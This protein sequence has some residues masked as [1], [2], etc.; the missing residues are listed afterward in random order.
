M[1]VSVLCPGVIRTALFRGHAQRP[2]DLDGETHPDAATLALYDRL[3]AEAPGPEVVADAA[4]RAVL[5]DRLFVLTGPEVGGL[6]MKRLRAVRDALPPH[7]KS[8]Q[9]AR[10]D[11]NL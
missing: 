1:G 5:E 10:E 8:D 2:E 3:V 11:S 9:R 4:V 6:V 7:D